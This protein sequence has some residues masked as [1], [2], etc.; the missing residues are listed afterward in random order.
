MWNISRALVLSAHTDDMEFGAGGTVSRLI[1]EGI[2]V[3]SVV[4]SIARASVP[5]EFPEDILAHEVRKAGAVLGLTDN[6]LTVLD[7][8]VR[9]FPQYRQDI[10]EELIRIRRK[11]APQLILTPSSTDIHQDH[12][13]LHQE[14]L[15]A[16]KSATTLGYLVPWNNLEYRGQATV[17]VQEQDIEKKIK[18]L[19]E[20]KSQAARPYSN[21]DFLRGWARTCGIMVG[22]TYAETFEVICWTL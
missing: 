18:A 11:I 17:V 10:L 14:A 13:T 7:Y 15:R 19:Q 8:P 3:H 4:F 21:P 12:F 1:S 9:H 22:A 2:E 20:Y 16:F 6:S 5:E